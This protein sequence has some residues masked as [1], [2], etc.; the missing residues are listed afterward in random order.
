[1]NIKPIFQKIK[2][3]WG[4]IIFY[5]VI[6]FFVL[7]TDAKSWV[8]R[9]VIAT[10]VLNTAI[11]KDAPIKQQAGTDFSF[12]SPEGN[13]LNSSMLQGKV[14]FIN[15]WASWCPPCRAEMPSL[16]SLY[17]T[18]KNDNR[19]VFLFVSEDD[20]RTKASEYLKKNN[21]SIPMYYRNQ[22]SPEM[23]S[24]TLPTT[25]VLDKKGNIV[26]KHTGLAGYDNEKFITQLKS[27]L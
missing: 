6:L 18:L 19:F 1:M 3:H 20:D 17:L 26:M 5:A 23:F 12:S 22:V 2:K 24:G 7:N 4:S 16:N 10:G 13:T 27:L 11:K 8:L 21:F 25:I 14:V 9:Q 15:F